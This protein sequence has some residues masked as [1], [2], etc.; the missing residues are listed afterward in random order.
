M[1]SSDLESGGTL[2]VQNATMTAVANAITAG[3]VNTHAA[4]SIDFSTTFGPLTD[5]YNHH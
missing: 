3:T 1:C 4:A 5:T 2:L